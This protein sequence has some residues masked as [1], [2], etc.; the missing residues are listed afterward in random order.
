M[1]DA[2][3]HD[4]LFDGRITAGVGASIGQVIKNEI[5]STACLAG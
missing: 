3:E 2:V 4:V 1:T 5:G